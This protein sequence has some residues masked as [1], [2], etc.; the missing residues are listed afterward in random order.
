MLE[1]ERT[2]KDRKGAIDAIQDRVYDLR[3]LAE[4]DAQE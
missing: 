3:Q 4:G 2:G 1:A